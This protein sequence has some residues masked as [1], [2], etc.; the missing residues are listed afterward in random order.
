MKI[1]TIEYFVPRNA[2]VDDNIAM[3]A[4]IKNVMSSYTEMGITIPNNIS[5]KLSDVESE[6]KSQTRA[7]KQAELLK[8]KSRRAA[9]MTA[10][11]KRSA[12]DAEIK[13]ME[14]SLV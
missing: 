13:A 8:L 2:S 5:T 1:S 12:L 3:R 9:L 7:M 4:S 10:D 11:E 14:D 6:I